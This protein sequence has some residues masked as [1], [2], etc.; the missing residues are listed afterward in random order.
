VYVETPGLQR[1]PEARRR[2]ILKTLKLA[3]ELGAEAVTLVGQD[4]VEKVLDYARRNN[5]GRIVVGRSARARWRCLVQLPFSGRL[6]MQATDIDVIAVARNEVRARPES[7]SESETADGQKAP[8]QLRGYAAA[9]LICV[10]VTVAAAPLRFQI[11]LANIVMLFLLGV[12]FVA[13]RFG[14]GPAAFAAVIN[15]AS[16]DFFFVPPHL[17]FAVSDVQYLLTFAV[18]LIVGLVTG[19]LTAGL[20][21]QARVAH[22]REQ[23]ARSLSDMAKSLSSALVE[24]QVVEIADRF[25][26]STFFSKVAIVLP[27]AADRLQVATVRGGT[28]AY[29][30]AV[31]QWC[32]DKNAPAGVGTD[33]LPASPQLYLPLK[34]PMR[35]RGVL[36]VEPGNPR[37]LMIPEQRRL[38]DTFAALIAIALER[39]HFVSVAQETLIKMESERLRN[40]LLAALSHDLRTPL[41]ALVGLAETLSLELAAEESGRAKKAD[42][43]REQA[44]RTTRMVNNLLEMA[45]LQSGELK[46]RKDWQS[47]EEIA[48]SALKGLETVLADRPVGVELAADLPLVRCD[49]AL[50]ERVLVNLVENAIKYTPAGTAIGIKAAQADAV[51]RVEVWDDGPG[52]PPGQERVIFEKFARGDKESAIPGTGLGLAICEAIV[53]AHAGKIWA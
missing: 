35:V 30:V 20:R 22:A 11:D 15:V 12:V 17:T 44:L 32:Y 53:Q 13:Y 51:L 48:G 45:K 39:I 7:V 1:L 4:A 24:T 28:P 3:Q 23:R 46:P 19:H 10:F 36:V 33:T 34:A 50:I 25:L 18:M 38:L 29:D 37:L 43:I 5:L 40:S 8:R 14:R 16:F 42:L 41:T 52:L 31:A 9:L 26:E 27:D 2:G 21:F 47:I 49:A 6:G